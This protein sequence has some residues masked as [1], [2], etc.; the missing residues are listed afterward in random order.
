MAEIKTVGEFVE[1]VKCMRTAQKRYFRTKN[2]IYTAETFEKEVALE[3]AKALE[4]A[5]DT[6]IKEYEKRLEQKTQLNLF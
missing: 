5:V 2:S 1:L 6:A 3:D 4:K